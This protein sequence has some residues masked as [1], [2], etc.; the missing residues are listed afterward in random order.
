MSH[1]EPDDRQV[2]T[3][4]D[5]GVDILHPFDFPEKFLHGLRNPGFHLLGRRPR[6]GDEDVD[7]RHQDLGLFL[8]RGDDDRQKSEQER[9]NDDQRRQFGFDERLGDVSRYSD[10]FH[11]V[12][13]DFLYFLLFH[14]DPPSTAFSTPSNDDP[15]IRLQPRQDLQTAVVL[16]AGPH[17]TV[18]DDVLTVHGIDAGELSLF[19]DGGAGHQ[20]DFF[21]PSGDPAPWRKGRFSARGRLRRPSP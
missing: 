20:E 5:D 1:V 2:E 4:L 3:G 12:L 18:G 19:N 14:D 7:H 15:V 6:I 17:Q 11:D 21:F 16:L 9:C 10:T 13:P 8:A